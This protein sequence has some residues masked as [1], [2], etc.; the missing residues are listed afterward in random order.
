MKPT[1]RIVLLAGAAVCAA[2]I[3]VAGSAQEQVTT[4][5]PAPP[6][7]ATAEP[8]SAE[9]AAT[10]Q[11]LVSAFEPFTQDDFSVLTGNVQR[12]NGIAFFNNNLY[13]ACT[14]DQT[15]YETNS[16]TGR[17]QTYLF[18]LNNSHS[19][20]VEEGNGLPVIWAVDYTDNSLKRI[21]RGVGVQRVASNL[22][23][24]WGLVAETETTF[25]VS[26][27]L[28]RTLERISRDGEQEV[29]L[30]DLPGPTGLAL[31]D[32][33]LYVANNGSTRRAIEWYDRDALS[34]E[35]AQVLVSGLQN[36]TGL[37][38]AAD[39]YLYFAYAVGTRGVVGRV[40]PAECREN[41]GCTNEQVDI[42]AYTELEAPL[43]GLTVTPDLRLFVHTMFSPSI[44]WV[45]LPE[46]TG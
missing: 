9:P 8:V 2:A 21:V 6:K 35:S 30:E 24:P 7:T 46:P 39:G 14:G 16:E 44:F 15:V 25:L 36:T 5:T 22:N 3:S 23:G 43:A 27:L 20:F 29:V 28:G 32:Q 42:V 17:T 38:L 4:P 40:N 10:G 37:Q 11:P 41:G 13:I 1:I 34:T 26:N 31:D 33:H 19:L 18:G 12:P 45:Q